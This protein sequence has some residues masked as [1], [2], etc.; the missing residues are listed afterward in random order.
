MLK[1]LSEEYHSTTN[2]IAQIKNIKSTAW[3]LISKLTQT[4]LTICLACCFFT[5]RLHLQFNLEQYFD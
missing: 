2:C 5:K 1:R 4:M 3:Y